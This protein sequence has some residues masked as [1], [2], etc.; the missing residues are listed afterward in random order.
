M[1]HARYP[2]NNIGN[3]ILRYLI[4]VACFISFVLDPLTKYVRVKFVILR[5]VSIN[6]VLCIN[7]RSITAACKYLVV[8]SYHKLYMYG[9]D[10]LFI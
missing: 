9:K 7:F 3:T 6:C 4:H 1:M 10:I 2:I 8:Y 5:V